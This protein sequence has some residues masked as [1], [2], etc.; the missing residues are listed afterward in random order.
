[1]IS[2]GRACSFWGPWPLRKTTSIR[3][4]SLWERGRGQFGEV[5]N[6]DVP[7][8]RHHHGV[9]SHLDHKAGAGRDRL[10]RE[11]FLIRPSRP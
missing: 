8:G 4:G 2:A 9:A 6:R 1:M 7:V 3:D 5:R 11:L 10:A